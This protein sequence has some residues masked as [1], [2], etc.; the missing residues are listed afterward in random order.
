MAQ[1]PRYSPFMRTMTVRYS[2]DRLALK[3]IN[4]RTVFRLPHGRFLAAIADP[5]GNGDAAIIALESDNDEMECAH[6]ADRMAERYAES[7]RQ[8]REE[9]DAR[10]QYEETL[11]ERLQ[12]NRRQVLTVIKAIKSGEHDDAAH[13]RWLEELLSQR[14]EYHLAR[15]ELLANYGKTDGW[16]TGY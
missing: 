11:P 2:N 10:M 4:G 1:S 12:Y 13:Y 3:V 16:A 7:E 8:Y 9:S 14:A 15:R 6:R 5:N